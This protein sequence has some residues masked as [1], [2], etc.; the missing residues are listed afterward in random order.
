M[1]PATP[2]WDSLYALE[3]A[4]VSTLDEEQP[5]LVEKVSSE[6]IA[7]FT[8]T[9]EHQ[10]IPRQEI[11]AVWDHLIR[12]ERMGLAEIARH[13]PDYAAYVAALLSRMPGVSYTLDP[14]TL[15]LG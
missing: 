2:L 6:G 8:S 14:N 1:F 9:G 11:E 4:T 12:A 7:I 10:V 15:M 13:S 3:G 5:F